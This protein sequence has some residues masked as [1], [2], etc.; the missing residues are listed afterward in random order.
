[1]KKDERIEFDIKTAESIGYKIFWVGILALFLFRR[2]YLNQTFM[3]TFDIFI[4]W[5][6][7]SIFRLITFSTKGI[8]ITYPVSMNKK[9]Q[10]YF[11]ILVPLFSGFLS[12]IILFFFTQGISFRRILGGFAGGFLGTLFLFLLYKLI[13]HFWEKKNTE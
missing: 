13:I 10:L 9:E 11:I 7:A 12:A 8:P 2:F 4:I 3:D 1:M 6:I 5:F